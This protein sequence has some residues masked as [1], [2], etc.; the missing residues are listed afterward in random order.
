VDLFSF[1]DS[2]VGLRR[3]TTD[4]SREAADRIAPS[5]DYLRG[6]VLETLA[7]RGALTAD[8]CAAFLC[9]DKLS[10]RPRFTELRE[11]GLIRDTG[12][13][14]ANASGRRAIVWSRTAAH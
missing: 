12:A 1:A 13:R 3:Q 4:T 10:I 11:A 8:E 2:R 14:R 5:T 7:Q 6:K 9:I